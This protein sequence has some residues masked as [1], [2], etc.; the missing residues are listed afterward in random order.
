MRMAVS[1]SSP[2]IFLAKINQLDLLFTLF[3][4]IFIPLA[5]FQEV[6]INGKKN[7]QLDAFSV[8]EKI[9]EGKIEVK[10]LDNAKIKFPRV[11]HNALHP[12]ELEAI[13]LALSLPEEVILLDDEE[14]RVFARAL[15]LQVKGTLG[16]LIDFKKSGMIDHKQALEILRQLNSLMYLSGDLYYFVQ[17]QLTFI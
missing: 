9:T 4:K 7:G 2:L 15:G 11:T 8:E 12:G 17:T 6:V 10:E 3:D 5:V 16:L 13:H 1:N 14:A